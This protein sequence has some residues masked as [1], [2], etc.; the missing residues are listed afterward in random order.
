MARMLEF[1]EQVG[2]DAGRL[3]RL[4]RD[5]GDR[6]ADRLICDAMEDLALSLARIGRAYA[7]RDSARIIDLAVGMESLCAR[8]GLPKLERVARSVAIC[9]RRGDG[10]GLDA[11]LAR[12][13]RVGDR[14]LSAVWDP[15]YHSV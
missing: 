15:H 10:A 4:Y 5:V 7:A 14:S 1:E 13:S 12:L 11:T 6:E 2:V 3:T 9:A 8:I